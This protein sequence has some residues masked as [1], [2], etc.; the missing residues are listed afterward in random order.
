MEPGGN[1]NSLQARV[2]LDS[3]AFPEIP[4]IA[5]MRG[6]YGLKASL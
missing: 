3:G 4:L 1:H 5:E 2:S 6:S